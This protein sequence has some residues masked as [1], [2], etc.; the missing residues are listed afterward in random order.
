MM[1]LPVST[2]TATIVLTILAVTVPC[3]AWF[4]AGSHS[5]EIEADQLIGLMKLRATRTASSLAGRIGGRLGL[6]LDTESR[7]PVYQYQHTYTDPNTACDCASITPSPLALGP[8]DALIEAQF[9]ITPTGQISLP[10]LGSQ[11]QGNEKVEQEWLRRQYR[12]RSRLQKSATAIKTAVE[13]RALEN[14]RLGVEARKMASQ[15]VPAW[16][17]EDVVVI[18]VEVPSL[19]WHVISLEGDSTLM[20]LRDVATPVGTVIQ[21][22]VVSTEGVTKSMEGAFFP[23][24]F[25]PGREGGDQSIGDVGARVPIDGV[26]WLVCVNAGDAIVRAKAEGA[27]IARQFRITFVLS[28]AAALI[29]GLFV[30]GLVWQSERLSNER[31]QFAAAAAHELRTPLA[32]LQLY[33]DMLAQGLGNQDKSRDYAS[34][35]AGEAQR[36]GRVVSN[37]LG[38]S[39]LERRSV[40]IRPERGDLAGAVNECLDRLRPAFESRGLAIHLRKNDEIQPVNFDGEALF[41]ILQNLLDNAEKF[42]RKTEQRDVDVELLP[43]KGGVALSVSDRGEGIPDHHKRKLFRSFSPTSREDAPPGL[44][45]GL[46]IVRQF[47]E[48]QGGSV[49]CTDTPGGG[50]TFTV[51]FLS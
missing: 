17:G 27:G 44:G 43:V 25:V 41:H 32:G 33:S 22:F 16:N 40:K 35:I 4:I 7:R 42:T 26:D 21:G 12:L 46:L 6:L 34:R 1:K 39:Q 5:V 11:G 29:A 48:L 50:A 51:T 18:E 19:E 9:Q 49:I 2:I 23:A 24:R 36:L 10:T 15:V 20:A 14:T 31:S 47:A 13:N 3:T 28:S 37:V 8:E 38:F 45:L 30:I